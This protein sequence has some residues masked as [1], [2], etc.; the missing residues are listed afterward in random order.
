MENI[1][2]HVPGINCAHCVHTIKMELMELEG[3][4]EVTADPDTKQVRVVY[5]PPATEA[6]I[7]SL[8]K[9]INYPGV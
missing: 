1:T 2:L 3:V 4:Q 7:K 8:L 5:S 6:S 9:E